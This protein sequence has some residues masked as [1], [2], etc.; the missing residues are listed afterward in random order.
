M[1]ENMMNENALN[2]M[3]EKKPMFTIKN[4]MRVL[5]VLCIIFVFCPSFLVSCS[6][7][8]MKV[9]VMTAVGGVSMY[10]EKVVEPHIIMLVC[11]LIPIAILVL[12]FLKKFKD[13]LTAGIILGCTAVDM[14]VWIIFRVSVKKIAEDN[15]CTFETTP[16]Y[17]INIIVMILIIVLSLLVVLNIM[18]MDTDLITF[19]S[20]GGTKSVLDQM[21]NTVSQ[22][23][24]AVTQLAGN[25]A[26][27]INNKTQKKDA[28]GFCAK[29]G[30]PIPY[31]TKFCTSCG[32]PVPESM[33]AAAEAARKEAEEKA[34][35]AAEAARRE[36]E[37][38]ARMAAEAAQ[39]EAE[40]RARM[41][42]T[43]QA[44]QSNNGN[45]AMFCQNCGAQ[46]EAD[47]VFCK[48]CGTKVR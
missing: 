4:I 9:D 8:D 44:P 6:G 5:S 21:S 22:M 3:S 33:I 1:N 16:W 24:N 15:Y 42:A 2:N 39:R 25:V 17:V 23:S 45:G 28:I 36:A 19:F 27:N 47:A 38:K 40:E 20:G 46:L 35:L 26:E 29:C 31:G 41:A 13:N 37:E 7:Q 11:L 10:G 48:A 14:I 30:S 12:L 18:M 34:R 43:E 32:T